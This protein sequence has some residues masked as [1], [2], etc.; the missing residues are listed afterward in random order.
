VGFVVDKV[1]VGQI[2]SEYFSFSCQKFHRLVHIYPHP[3]A[4]TISE[5]VADVPRGLSPTLA[6]EELMAVYKIH[7]S[8]TKKSTFQNR[9]TSKLKI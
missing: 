9:S 2:F 7:L 4:G 5:I 3:G 8:E 6:Q 1:T